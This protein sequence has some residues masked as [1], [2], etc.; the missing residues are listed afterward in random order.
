MSH[1]KLKCSHDENRRKVCAPCGRKISFGKIPPEKFLVNENTEKLIRKFLFED[2]DKD[3]DKFPMSICRSCYLALL[4]A[5]KGVS[6]RSLPVMPN[7]KDIVLLKETRTKVICNCYVCLTGKHHGHVKSLKG[8]GKKRNSNIVIDVSNGIHESSKIE[9]PAI[10]TVEDNKSKNCILLCKKCFQEI[11]RGKNH[12]CKNPAGNLSNIIDKLSGKDQERIVTDIVKKK[13]VSETS[14]ISK[15]QNVELNFATA[16]R[17]SRIIVNPTEEKKQI[18]FKAESL[19]NIRINLG[20]STNNMRKITN[21]LRC[22]VGKKSI[23]A[24]YL[25]HM[26]DQSNI[27]KDVYKTGCHEF[28]CENALSKQ[29]RSVVYADAEELLDA[30]IKE[31]NIEG[32]ILIKAMADGGQGFFKISLTILPENYSPSVDCSTDQIDLDDVDNTISKDSNESTRKRT[33]YSKGGTMSKRGKLSSV[34]KLILL[35]VVPQIKETYEN[36]KLLFELTNIN[37]I[38]FKFVSDFKLLLIINGQ[39]TATAT[40]PCPYCFVSRADLK[41]DE[42]QKALSSS[43]VQTNSI[44][45][46][47]RDDHFKLK[48]YGDLRKDYEMFCRV[49][50]DERYSKECHSTVN[51]PLFTED[52]D[53]NVLQKCIIPELHVL[54]GFV[55]HLFWKGL[56]PLLGREK[57]LLW[58]KKLKLIPKNYHG[59]SFEGN[60]CR[61]LLTEVDKLEDPEIYKDVGYFRIVPYISALKA[62]NKVVN[63][64]FTAGKVG[65]SLDTYISELDTALKSIENL[66]TTLKIHVILAHIQESFQ[67]IDDNNALGFWS[68]QSGESVHREFLKYWNRYKINSINDESYSPRLLKAVVEFSSLH[69]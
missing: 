54:Q 28:E 52:D 32:N 60:A 7:Y 36:V 34:D 40:F 12:V 63:C 45:E 35:C 46:S 66:S 24:N 69:I 29:N 11:G 53:I 2:F 14:D 57:A 22:N 61:K 50:K 68:E 48:T 27:L 31:R 33:L 8:R 49:G 43:D 20:A 23:P 38:P 13:I 10:P 39:Q 15:L 42:N 65:P 64:C 21:F 58:P 25:K 3:N 62:M 4:D 16:G 41:S 18:K 67:Y 6:G 17:T 55:N 47:I 56:I 19:D 9:S 51:L 5:E 37:S 59:D 26:S 44:D 30:V 1:P